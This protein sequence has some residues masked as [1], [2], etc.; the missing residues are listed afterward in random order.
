MRLKS[1]TLSNS[2]IFGF[3]AIWGSGSPTFYKYICVCVCVCV[4]NVYI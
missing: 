4:V 3:S 2:R 1:H